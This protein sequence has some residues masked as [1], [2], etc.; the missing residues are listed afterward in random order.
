MEFRSR[1]DFP[2]SLVTGVLSIL[3]LG[4][5][6]V[7]ASEYVK[8]PSSVNYTVGQDC[9]LNCTFNVTGGGGWGE[10]SAV[11][12]HIYANGKHWLANH[13]PQ[14][15][16]RTSLSDSELQRGDASLLLRRVTEK[17]AGKY[18]CEVT[19]RNK[20]GLELIELVLDPAEPT[21]PPAVLE[22]QRY[23]FIVVPESSG[24]SSTDTESSGQCSTDTESQGQ[25]RQGQCRTGQ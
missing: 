9:I 21:T 19:T 7:S 22:G 4:D 1:R 25:L 12:V 15:V 17:D 2:V 14:C 16:N 5:C 18:Q 6:S 8:V 24:Q 10:R 20:I 13:L 23:C 11:E 3:T